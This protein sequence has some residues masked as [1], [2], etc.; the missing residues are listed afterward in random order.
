MLHLFFILVDIIHEQFGDP[1]NLEEA[2]SLS[3]MIQALNPKLL[4]KKGKDSFYAFKY[5]YKDIYAAL[6]SEFLRSF[7]EVED[8]SEDCTPASIQK[9]DDDAEKQVA[10]SNLVRSFIIRT[11]ADFQ[12][13]SENYDPNLTLPLYYPHHDFLRNKNGFSGDASDDNLT[14]EDEKDQR[15]EDE[16]IPDADKKTKRSKVKKVNDDEK[17]AYGRSLLSILG[18]FFT[19]VDAASEGNGLLAFIIQKKLHKAIWATGHK[20]YAVSLL[21]YKHNILGHSNPQFAHQ[22]LWNTSAGRPGKGNKFP[23]DQKVEHFNR[24]LKESFRSLGPNLNP[25]TAKRLNNSSEFGLKIEE[26]LTDFFELTNPGQSHTTKDHS[27]QVKKISATLRSEKIATI[28]PSRKFKGPQ[29]KAD[30]FKSF[31]E[32]KFRSWHFA[33]DKELNRS[34]ARFR[35]NH[36][37]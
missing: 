33:K 6:I 18:T 24:Y 26:K 25:K 10:F 8:F 20:N 35:S 34:S 36:L 37:H 5:V 7:L 30:F 28:V 22:F 17:N 12:N 21:S 14:E 16:E 27:A 19:L 15:E 11:H 1:E 13:C 3:R 9:I 2:A 23:R 4:N 31:D 32:A 29:M